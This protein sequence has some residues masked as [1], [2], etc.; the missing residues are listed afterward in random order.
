MAN[1]WEEIRFGDLCSIV[2]GG[3]PRPIH[4]FLREEGIPWIKISD[5]TAT[6][7]R[8]IKKTK[9]FI[10]EEGKAKTREVYP[11]DLIVSNSAT[12][13]IPRF[14]DIYA[15][16]HDGWLLL[17]DFSGLDKEYCFYLIENDRPKLIQQGNGSVFTNLKTDILKNHIVS[18]PDIAEQKAIA[19]FLGALDDKIELNRQINATLES[20]AQALFK[21]W[22]VDFDPVIDNA[23]VAGNPIPEP[24]Q[25]RA[26]RRADLL[27]AAS[28]ADTRS[29]SATDNAHPTQT[30]PHTQP[31]TTAPAT[32]LQPLPADLRALFPDSFVFN[33][34][35][36]WVP[37]GWE[38]KQVD[39]LLEL[40]YGKAL[41][42]KNRLPGDV[43]VYGSGGVSGFHNEAIVNAPGIIVGRK[44][45]VGSLYWVEKEFFPIDTVFY[46][47][48]KSEMPL[49][50]LYRMLATLGIEQMGADSAVPGVNRNVVYG[51][52]VTVPSK[53]VAD[54]FGETSDSFN[55]KK[56]CLRDQSDCLSEIR[57]S[58][59]PK[60]LSGKIALPEAQSLA[61]EGI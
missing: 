27:A 59:L 21:S 33:E 18:L 22:F 48:N 11:G 35:M 53:A 47:K 58:L 46:V 26:E 56:R 17:R 61:E 5:A 40:A 38:V 42:A 15:C 3:S 16:I 14:L 12:P 2:R 43:P 37:E 13:G 41:A 51:C 23:L 7:S 8:Y 1:N 39:D 60:L 49:Y 4:D 32:P 20:M 54:S 45:T 10:R 52:K 6:N 36:G 9:Q 24:L 55:A 30:A 31:G 28:A 19:E 50:W 25:A 44:G 29:A 34:E 57:D